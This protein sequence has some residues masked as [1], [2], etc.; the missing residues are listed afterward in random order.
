MKDG[1]ICIDLY[2]IYFDIPTYAGAKVSYNNYL[3]P[4]VP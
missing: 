2:F 1:D 3:H 4:E